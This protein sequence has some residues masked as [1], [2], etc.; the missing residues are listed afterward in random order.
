MIRVVADAS[1]LIL[2]EK[3]VLLDVLLQHQIKV[4]IPLEVEK[5]AVE[6]G[7]M[8]GYPG[9]LKLEEKIKEG[10]ITVKKVSEESQVK[11]LRAIFKLEVEEAEAIALL[12]QEKADLL[13]TDD[14]F[15]MKACHALNVPTSGS[16]AFV[17]SSFEKGLIKKEQS[18][19]MMETLAR[20]G[21]YKD[22]IIFEA[23]RT[24]LGGN[25]EKR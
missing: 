19:Q 18:V 1:S 10:T 6:K 3:I 16:V 8:Q 5:E 17:I 24:I 13:A 23:L 9:A 14:K 21:R 22:D 11:N 20:E 4:M 12:Q 25:H 7:K 15:A 2:L